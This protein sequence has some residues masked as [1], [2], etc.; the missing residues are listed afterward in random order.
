[1]NKN[2]LTIALLLTATLYVTGQEYKKDLRS[3]EVNKVYVVEGAN[4]NYVAIPNFATPATLTVEAWI[5]VPNISGTKTIISWEGSDTFLFRLDGNKLTIGE[6]YGGNW[7]PKSATTTIVANQW[8]HVAATRTGNAVSFYVN[9]QPAGTA[10]GLHA[11]PSNTTSTKLSLGG[12][13]KNSSESF[14]GHLDEVRIWN[15]VRT[16]DEIAANYDN[17][18]LAGTASGLM[19]YWQFNGNLTD[20]STNGRNGTA[21]NAQYAERNDEPIV[22]DRGYYFSKKTYV[23]E[24]IPAYNK[25]NLP[26]PIIDGNPGWVNMYNKAWQLGFDHIKKPVA[27]SPFVSNWYDEWFDNNIYQWDIIFMTMFSKYGHFVFPGIQ[28]LDNFYCS[29][30]KSGSISRTITEATGAD[31]FDDN[32]ANQINPPLFSWVEV[33][34]YKATGDKSRFEMVFPVLEKYYEYVDSKRNG[35]DTPHKLYWSNGQSSGMDNTPRDTGRNNG[36]Y[37][38]DHHG[39]VDASAQMIIQCN[40]LAFICD[41]LG[42]TEKAANYRAKATAIGQRMNQYMWNA[43]DGLYY[44]VNTAGTKTQWKTIAAFG[45]MLAGITTPAQDT[46]LVNNLKNPALFNRDIPFATLAAS[47]AEYKPNGGYWQGAVWA[48]TSYATLKGLETVGQNAAA[49]ELAEKYVEGVY[50]VYLQTG[51]LW[52]N[53]AADK[54]DG[55][56]KQGVNDQNPPAD[57]RR[58]FVG[59]TGLVPISV[60]IENVLGFRMNGAEKILT[61]DLRRTDRHGIENLRMADVTTSVVTDART[62]TNTAH[63][64]VTSDKPYTLEILF[65]GETFIREIVAGT[66]EIDLNT[67]TDIT[68]VAGIT[69]KLTIQPNPVKD[70]LAFELNTATAQQVQIKILDTTGKEVFSGSDT[71]SQ[72]KFTQT[73][74][75]QSLNKGIFLLAV[76]TQEGRFIEKFIKK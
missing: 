38:T 23:D 59:W 17:Y 43:S 46:A 41:E 64:T 14:V 68:P 74:N 42:Y 36:H 4:K 62:D 1:M 71:A 37:S 20:K 26:K 76:L 35:N 55:K 61:Y 11:S 75:V 45:A 22:S 27:G 29:Q 19:G 39:W 58:D 15:T 21:S 9:G 34:N 12:L 8:T 69:S 73:I 5:K 57:C 3:Q 50:Q 49:N 44:D 7:I 67:T 30:N 2:I 47:H 13:S 70:V 56:F 25:E 48:P 63:L 18:D 40:N 54:V 10:T 28:S 66:Q 24:P 32:N 60:L 72:G 6:D 31:H 65:N 53:Y 52:E 16:A 51:T 33:E